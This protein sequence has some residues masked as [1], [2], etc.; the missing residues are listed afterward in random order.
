MDHQNA[1]PLTDEEH[2]TLNAALTSYV[3]EIDDP[4]EAQTV[5]DLAE[6][7]ISGEVYLYLT[8]ERSRN[9][10]HPNEER[11]KMENKEV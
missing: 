3:D 7:I 10:C 11:N 8:A 6:A 4:T 5:R 2:G 1:R 9:S